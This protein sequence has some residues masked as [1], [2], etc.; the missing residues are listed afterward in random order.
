M[1]DRGLAMVRSQSSEKSVGSVLRRYVG[2]GLSMSELDG[3][4]AE[5]EYDDD[6]SA[7]LRDVLASV[8][9]VIIEA[10]E[11]M[12]QKED[13][14]VG[15]TRALASIGEPSELVISESKQSRAQ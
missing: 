10:G 12:A 6:L 14:M 11:G 9:L 2:G 7:P 1:T 5:A 4:L 8:R 3:W 15:V 13:V